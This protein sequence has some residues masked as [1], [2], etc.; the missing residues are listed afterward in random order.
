MLLKVTSSG[1]PW[2]PE[3][4]D[5]CSMPPHL[6]SGSNKSSIPRARVLVTDHGLPETACQVGS[7]WGLGAC[8]FALILSGIGE[9]LGGMEKESKSWRVLPGAAHQQGSAGRD[10]H[11]EIDDGVCPKA[12]HGEELQVPL[13]ILGIEAGNGEPVPEASLQADRK[14]VR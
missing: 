10:P 12:L 2:P 7:V 1:P 3:P 4:N 14:G 5:K 9:G 13:E 6:P 11:L 8:S